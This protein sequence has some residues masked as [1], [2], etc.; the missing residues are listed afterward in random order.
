MQLFRTEAGMRENV[1]EK[2][3][4]PKQSKN[5]MTGSQGTLH[6][7]KQTPGTTGESLLEHWRRQKFL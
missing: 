5:I 4:K 3:K 2:K 7:T 6:L 1:K